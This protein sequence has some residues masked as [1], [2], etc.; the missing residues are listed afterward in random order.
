[1]QTISDTSKTT[2]QWLAQFDSV[3]KNF[4]F[5]TRK[6]ALTVFEEKGFPTKKVEEWKYTDISAILKTS[7]EK[8]ILNEKISEKEIQKFILKDV[9]NHSAVFING[10]FSEKYSSIGT[11]PKGMIVSSLFEAIKKN[12]KEVESHFE[13][14]PGHSANSFV[15]LN[16][17]LAQDGAF[18]LIPD[19]IIFEETLQLV[20]ISV[21]ENKNVSIQPRN[22]II[23]GKNSGAKIIES[24][25]SLD[26]GNVFTNSVTEIY[27]GENSSVEH[28]TV[29]DENAS[30]NHIGSTLIWQEA[31]SKLHTFTATF[32]KAFFRNNLEITLNGK[33]SEAVLN[34]F[35]FASG[36][37]QIDNYTIVD[38]AVPNCYSNQMYKGI[39]TDKSHCVFNGRII[40]RKDAQKTNAFQSNKNILMTDEA[41]VN[42]LPQLEIFADDVKCSHGSTTGK[43]DQEALFYLRA[44]GIGEQKAKTMLVSAFAEEIINQ[45]SITSLKEYLKNLIAERL[46]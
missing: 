35:Y 42:S 31:N 5:D 21:S 11:I 8:G 13:K 22:I 26:A 4:L 39:L 1:M 25:Y 19:K 23:T 27:I 15:S 3:E 9:S 32:G 10:Y 14:F 33:N 20:F 46:N 45:I 34:G 17:A 6:K 30:A 40:V 12:P 43:I 28:C 18:V 29:S 41:T 7:Y 2:S 38:H 37:S 24:Y 16:T 44:R 36:N